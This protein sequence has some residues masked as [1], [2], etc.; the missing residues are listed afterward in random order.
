LAGTGAQPERGAGA[1]HIANDRVTDSVA[2]V[3]G[4]LASRLGEVIPFAG[5]PGAQGKTRY[6]AFISYSHRDDKVAKWLHRAIETYRV[7]RTLVGKQGDYGPVPRRVGPVFRDEEELSGAAELGPKLHGALQDSAALI[8]ICSCTSAKSFWVDQEI[9][10]FKRVNPGRPVLAV[11]AD[12]VPGSD[13]EECFPEA[14]K[15]HVTPEGELDRDDPSEPLAPDL[16][17]LDK[18]VVRLKLIAGLLGVG[19]NDLAR[20]DLKRARRQA[21]ILTTLS[22]TIMVVLASLSVAALTY[23]RIAVRERNRAE[24]Q[25]RIAEQ[26]AREAEEKYW[27][28]QAAAAFCKADPLPPAEPG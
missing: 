4:E 26:H 20:R 16:T 23:A 24:E 8:V 3:A 18:G 22:V 6:A 25:T 27:I 9:R 11:I 10:F 15:Y 17:K 7:P 21:A 28:A 14:L 5:A 19:Y 2:E 12:G 13:G 1:D